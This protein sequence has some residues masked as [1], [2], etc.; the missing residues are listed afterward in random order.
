MFLT[1]FNTN[2]DI[3]GAVEFLPGTFSKMNCNDK[4][5][6]IENN[7]INNGC[8]LQLIYESMKSSNLLSNKFFVTDEVNIYFTS[9]KVVT[10]ISFNLNAESTDNKINFIEKIELN[11]K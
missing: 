5:C 3:I 7:V 2:Q 8:K 4:K 9:P 11:Y 10:N 6:I 1:F